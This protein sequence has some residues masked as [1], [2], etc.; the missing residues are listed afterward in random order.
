MT[1]TAS[2][3]IARGL[4]ANQVLAHRYL[5][6]LKPAEFDHQPFPG[7]NSA[8]WVLG[9]LVLTERRAL[10]ALGAEL[11]ELPAGFEEKFKVTGQPAPEQGH[12]GEPAQLL[13]LFDA[14]RDALVRAVEAA[15]DT[16]LSQEINLSS[17]SA[18]LYPTTGEL[19]AFMGQHTALHLGQVTVIRRSL[20]YPPV[21]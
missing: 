17:R 21:L 15:A 19:A 6:D 11:P 16:H 9:H 2:S 5:D 12:L 10:G 3:A 20:G 13:R 1:L 4:R 14:H 8:A 18:A 7:V